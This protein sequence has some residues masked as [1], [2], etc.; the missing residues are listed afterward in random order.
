MATYL[1]TGATGLIGRHFVAEVLARVDTERV[2]VLVRERSRDR[3]ARFASHCRDVPCRS[4][5]PSNVAAK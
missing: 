5:H 4:M 3:L 1:V 2:W